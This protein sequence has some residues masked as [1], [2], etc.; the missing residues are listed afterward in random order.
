MM[1]NKNWLE[2]EGKVFIVTGGSSGIGAAIVDE[3]LNDGAKVV[4]ADL[5]DDGKKESDY[6]FA[7][8]DVTSSEDV[9]KLVEKTL[10]KFGK[11]DGLVNNAGINI[12]RILVDPVDPN[13]K[14]VIDE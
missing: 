10:E 1:E 3:L 9:K 8:T 11:I 4:N 12:P 5:K 13:G 14:Y 7:K 6:L 2:L